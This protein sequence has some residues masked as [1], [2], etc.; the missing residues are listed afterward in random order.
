MLIR[1]SSETNDTAILAKSQNYTS[2]PT[3]LDTLGR[4]HR[5]EIVKM[6]K[7]RNSD[8]DNLFPRHKPLNPASLTQE[9]VANIMRLA[10]AYGMSDVA[11]ARLLLFFRSRKKAAYEKKR[12]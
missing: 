12:E 4:K 8:D 10:E 3:Q 1:G 6:N 9:E 5:A 2:E 7:I 11:K